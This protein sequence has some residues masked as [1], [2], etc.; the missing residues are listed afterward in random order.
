VRE[1]RVK[2]ACA[3]G[4]VSV[5]SWINTNDLLCAQIMAHAG[6]DWLLVDMEHGPVPIS[7]LQAAV[8]AI[9][10]T[11]V[12]PFVRA[13]WK[14]SAS[15]QTALDCGASGVMVPMVNTRADAEAVVRDARFSP[16]GERSRGGVRAGFSF[17]VDASTY[18]RHAND[19]L[20]VIAQIETPQA[21]DNLD[22]IA[23]VEGIDALFVGPNDL[24][25]GY[26]VEYPAGW[27][28]KTG[29]YAAAIDRVPK[30]ARAHG[31]IPGILA[32]SSAMA[33]ECIER[34]YTLVGVSSDTS[35]LIAAAKKIRSEVSAPPLE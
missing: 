24:A 22:E 34:G 31:K 28:T 8:T 1:N 2:L 5:G 33:N 32:S 21:I 17:G 10:T 30:A 19:R 16:Q 6:F 27:D 11:A 29:A 4:W 9:R 20:L 25:A 7:A 13:S 14:S 18:F 35:L 26:D 15:I 3:Q 12:E 23:A